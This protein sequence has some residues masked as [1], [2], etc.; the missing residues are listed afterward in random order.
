M[1]NEAVIR[2]I[3]DNYVPVAVNI[4]SMR[5][6]DPASQLFQAV[7]KQKY[8]YQGVW[9]VD[10]AGNMTLMGLGEKNLDVRIK[11]FIDDLDRIAKAFATVK[12]RSIKRQEFQPW[13]GVGVQPDGKVTL[14]LHVRHYNWTTGQAGWRNRRRQHG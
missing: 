6:R 9:I 4:Y 3:S 14:A 5:G 12:P 13:R 11:K 10:P 1:N 7:Q 8:S 2:H